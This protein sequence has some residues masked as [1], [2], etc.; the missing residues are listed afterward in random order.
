[1]LTGP[2]DG[3]I[4]ISSAVTLSCDRAAPATLPRTC[5]DVR[6]G[7]FNDPGENERRSDA[8][9]RMGDNCH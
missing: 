9:D 6:D 3:A 5:D 8:R 7:N 4:I 2:G 1:M